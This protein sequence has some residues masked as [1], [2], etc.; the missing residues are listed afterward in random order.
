MNE[1]PLKDIHLPDM[2]LWWPPA[3]GWWILLILIAGL[4]VGL[5]YLRRWMKHKSVKKLSLIEFKKITKTFDQQEDKSKLVGELSILLRRIMMN[6]QGR[7]ST[8]A[9]TGDAWITHLNE[10]VVERCF[11]ANQES[12]LA[13][14]QY[15]RDPDV[16]IDSFIQSCERWIN[17]LPRHS[18]RV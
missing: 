2:S 3:V 12:L 8:A 17:S 15:Q 18:S 7:H 14:G 5:P 16:D 9:L 1:I 6:Y 11:N 13:Q 10:M 4:F